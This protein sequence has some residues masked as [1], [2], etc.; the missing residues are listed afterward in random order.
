MIYPLILILSFHI[1]TVLSQSTIDNNSGEMANNN[2]SIN[3]EDDKEI[4]YYYQ[5]PNEWMKLKATFFISAASVS[6]IFLFICCLCGMKSA[7]SPVDKK[8]RKYISHA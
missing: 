7:C 8:K 2:T 4:V 1:T 6:L 3:G 5:P